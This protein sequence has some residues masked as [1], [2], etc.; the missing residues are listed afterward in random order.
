M[1]TETGWFDFLIKEWILLAALSGLLL[2]SIYLGRIPAY[3]RSDFEILFMLLVLFVCGKGMENSGVFAQLARRLERGRFTPLKLVAT[4]YGLSMFV[5]NDVAL[6]VIV[7]LTL[8]LRS[9]RRH[10]LVILEALAANSGSALTPFG[11]PQNLFLYWHY[12]LS[13]GQFLRAIAPLSGFFLVLLLAAASALDR[14]KEG[15]REETQP[16]EPLGLT[17]RVYPVLTGLMI[18]VVLKVLPLMAGLVALLYASCFDRRSLRVDYA[19]LLTFFVFFGLTDNIKAMAVLGGIEHTR[20]VFLLSAMA[21]QVMSNVPAALLL[22]DFT[23]NWKA[24]LW[25]SNVGGFGNLIASFANLIA[26]RLYVTGPGVTASQGRRFT[27]Q[28]LAA[29]YLSFFLGILL[30]ALLERTL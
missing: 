5:T 7:P 27:A 23:Q 15:S 20:H 26:Y 3:S 6:L 11:N 18:L 29:G 14:G 24:L 16:I 12:H 9:P 13:F 1:K 8:L 30:F 2:T 28:F 22:A 19:L 21:S 4:T 10:L 17:S 25:G